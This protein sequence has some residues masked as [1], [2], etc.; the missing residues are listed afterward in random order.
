MIRRPPVSPPTDSPFPYTTL[1]RPPQKSIPDAPGGEG[2]GPTRLHDST[3]SPLATAWPRWLRIQ[4]SRWLSFSAWSSSGSQPMAVGYKRIS[5]PASAISRA[6]S[7]YPWYHHTRT[8]RRP[9]AGPIGR[10]TSYQGGKL[11]FQ[12]KNGPWGRIT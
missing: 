2:S 7:V 8:P 1:F 4:A 11:T 6:A 12:E 5:A 9:T 3:G 10:K